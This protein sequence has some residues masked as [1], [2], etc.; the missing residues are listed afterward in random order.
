MTKRGNLGGRR[1]FG[2]VALRFFSL[3][4]V[5]LQ[6]INMLMQIFARY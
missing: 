5:G 2:K 3:Q 6:Y 4:Q 1:M